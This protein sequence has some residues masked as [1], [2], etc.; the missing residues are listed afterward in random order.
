VGVPP[1]RSIGLQSA[2][3]T[4]GQLFR[5]NLIGSLRDECLNVHWFESLTEAKR[6]LEDWRRDY[7]ESRPHSSLNDLTPVEYATKIKEL[8]AA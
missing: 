3:Q 4:H 6:I 7:N 5:R 1:R 8:G 2:R